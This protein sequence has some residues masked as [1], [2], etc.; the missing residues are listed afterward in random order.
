MDINSIADIVITGLSV[1]G[2]SSIAAAILPKPTTTAL[3]IFKIV[4]AIVDFV[5][6][7]WGNAK[8][9]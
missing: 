4:R 1:V 9:S 5:G 8:N 2:S 6:A 3:A 7:N